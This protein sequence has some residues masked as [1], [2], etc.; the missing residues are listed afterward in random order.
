MTSTEI[1][2]KR[3]EEARTRAERSVSP[4]EREVWLTAASEWTKLAH[5]PINGLMGA[6]TRTY[7]GR[8]RQF[9]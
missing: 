4:D 7:A 2:E 1:C 8:A 5:Q 3:A 6:F 9:P